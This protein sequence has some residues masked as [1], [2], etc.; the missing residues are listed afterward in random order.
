MRKIL[1][2]VVAALGLASVTM[3]AATPASAVPPATHDRVVPVRGAHWQ[4]GTGLPDATGRSALGLVQD[5]S[6]AGHTEVARLQGLTG[7]PGSA[8]TRLEVSSSTPSGIDPCWKVGVTAVDGS[9]GV[10][11]LTLDSAREEG[12]DPS[13]TPDLA[14]FTRWSWTFSIP[15]DSTISFV[16]LQVDAGQQAPAPGA[17]VAFDRFAVDGAPITTP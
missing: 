7:A 9:V 15:A 4:A 16:S 1:V 8:L 5:V 3:L 12:T 17:R 2:S 14:P 11:H 13:P 10:L 6:S